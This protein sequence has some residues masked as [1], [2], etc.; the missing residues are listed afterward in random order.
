M[1]TLSMQRQ[2]LLINLLI[3]LLF[4]FTIALPIGFVIVYALDYSIVVMN[5]EFLAIM[6]AAVAANL[7][8]FSLKNDNICNNRLIKVMMSFVLPGSLLF[9]SFC[10]LGIDSI[11]G[12][13]FSFL[14]VI[15]CGALTIIHGS[16]L[17]FKIITT[18]ISFMLMIPIILIT[19]FAFIFTLVDF[20]SVKTLQTLDSPDSKYVASIIERD[21]GAL[22]GSTTVDVCENF[23]VSLL[24]FEIRKKSRSLYE[25]HLGEGDNLKVYWK[26]NETLTINSLDYKVK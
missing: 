17:V 14:Y 11:F 19:W 18:V 21:E 8:V 12:F 20:V 2:K 16:P 24:L 3:S 13:V 4:S 1:H 7:V 25:G 10:L 26:D 23:K 22:G 15:C 5:Y 6:M 9:Y